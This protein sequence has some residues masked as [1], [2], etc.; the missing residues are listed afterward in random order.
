MEEHGLGLVAD[1]TFV[2]RLNNLLFFLTVL[3]FFYRILLGFDPSFTVLK[4]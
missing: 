2:E 3:T 4:F 1:V